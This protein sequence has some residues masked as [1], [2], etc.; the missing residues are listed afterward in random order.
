MYNLWNFKKIK[1]FTLIEVLVTVSIISILAAVIAINSVDAGKQSR[2]E[3]RQAD[4]R[5][6]QSAL[7]LYKN[8]YGR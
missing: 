2:D 6:L 5:N 4:I 8:K 3:K 1:G 7:E